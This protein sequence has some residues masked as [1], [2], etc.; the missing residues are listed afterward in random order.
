MLVAAIYLETLSVLIRS[1]KQPLDKL[2]TSCSRTVGPQIRSL[3]LT[4]IAKCRPLAEDDN[5][6][7]IRP[8]YS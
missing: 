7:A 3:I 8:Y 6:D 2:F 5:E 4:V 1:V